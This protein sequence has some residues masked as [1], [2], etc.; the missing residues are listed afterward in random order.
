MYALLNCFHSPLSHWYCFEDSSRPFFDVP[1]AVERGHDI[2]NFYYVAYVVGQLG[3]AFHDL[4][5]DIG[6]DTVHVEKVQSPADILHLG[7]RFQD[8]RVVQECTHPI[9]LSLGSLGILPSTDDS[10]GAVD[11]DFQAICLISRL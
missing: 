11:L 5:Y 1:Q 4:P 7:N 6:T 8:A 9:H 3:L 2:S 10:R